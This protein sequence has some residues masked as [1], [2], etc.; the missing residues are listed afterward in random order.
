MRSPFDFIAKPV[1]GRRYANSKE[2]GGIELITS[3]SD[4]DHMSSNRFAEV[5]AL[6]L[7]YEGPI[8][9]GNLLLVHHN[10]FKFYNDMQ[11]VQKSGKSWFKDDLF[12][13]DDM[14]YYMYHNGTE[15]NAVGHYS[16]IEPI[17]MKQ[18][19]GELFKNVKE[20]PLVGL[21]KYPSDMMKAVGVEP[22][23]KITYYP[24]MEYEFNV[25]EEKLY[26]LMDRHITVAL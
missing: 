17:K 16:F 25:D 18:V 10:V 21:M 19:D 11:G 15:W 26:R 9:I 12:F 7:N 1:D 5:V 20:E 2:I 13:I 23:D 3:T 6:P 4:E 8:E 22:G 24:G 14:Q